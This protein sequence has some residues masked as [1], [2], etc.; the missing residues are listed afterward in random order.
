M[1]GRGLEWYKREPI[2]YLGG[3]QGMTAR[4]HAVYSVVLELIYVHGGSV[5]NDPR[6]IAG[7]ISDMGAAAVRTTIDALVAGGKLD[8]DGENLTQK[9]A[10]NAVKTQEN[11]R[12]NAEK[13]GKKGGKKS[14]E[15]RARRKENNDLAEGLPSNEIQAEKIREDKSI[16][17]TPF[18]HLREV[19]SEQVARDFIDHRKGMKKPMSL[20]AAKAM[21]N[22]LRDH[23]NPDAVLLLSI[24]NGWQ[25][26]FPEKISAPVSI[27]PREGP[28]GG[29]TIASLPPIQPPPK[30]AS[31]A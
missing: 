1:S 20:Q 14:A 26:V 4:E 8:L 28:W 25:G 23:G 9:R 2:R 3:V 31:T 16:P 17:L 6:W 19:A 30:K 5:R 7:W 21:A 10:K 24:E 22:R 18:D 12:E 27:R 11:L 13:T 29:A 15:L